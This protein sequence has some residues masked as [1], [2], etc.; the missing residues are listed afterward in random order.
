MSSSLEEN[1][2][3]PT[4]ATIKPQKIP[5]IPFCLCQT[6]C[7]LGIIRRQLPGNYQ[8]PTVKVYLAAACS[9]AEYVNLRPSSLTLT[10][11]LWKL[12]Q[13]A[14]ARLSTPYSSHAVSDETMCKNAENTHSEKSSQHKIF[15]FPETLSNI[16]AWDNVLSRVMKEGLSRRFYG[17]EMIFQMVGC[18][19]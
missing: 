11:T 5:K 9:E 6:C 16:W 7:F 10:D 12:H 8:S 14:F 3:K 17:G 15:F 4:A 18:A 19:E 1:Q 2:T 13:E